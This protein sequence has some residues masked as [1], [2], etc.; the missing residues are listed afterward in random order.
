M[1]NCIVCSV[2]LR[3]LERLTQ[4]CSPHYFNGHMEGTK[5]VAE[6]EV[7]VSVIAARSNTP[8]AQLIPARENFSHGTR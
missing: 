4:L 5:Y 3:D 6:R 1:S 8:A 7:S 2:P